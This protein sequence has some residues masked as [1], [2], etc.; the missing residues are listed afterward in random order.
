MIISS[1]ITA[2]VMS[3]ALLYTICLMVF[4]RTANEV[5]ARTVGAICKS[6]G[7]ILLHSVRLVFT[8]CLFLID[9]LLQQFK[10]RH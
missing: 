10:S 7:V 9:A 6:T 3:L 5:F 2:L 4:N 1:V 8:G